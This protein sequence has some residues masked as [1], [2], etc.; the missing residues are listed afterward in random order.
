MAVVT[1]VIKFNRT[2]VL[3]VPKRIIPEHERSDVLEVEICRIGSDGAPEG[4]S[5][6]LYCLHNPESRRAFLSLFQLRPK[7]GEPFAIL[8]VR[9]YGLE[10]FANDYNKVRP[11]SLHNT[12]LLLVDARLVMRVGDAE[13]TIPHELK[14]NRGHVLLLG[15]FGEHGRQFKITKCLAGFKVCL[16][17]RHSPVASMKDESGGIVIR[18][19]DR[20]IPEDGHRTVIEIEGAKPLMDSKHPISS[21]SLMDGMRIVSK[22]MTFEGVYTLRSSQRLERFVRNKLSSARG[23]AQ[24]SHQRG[25]IAEGIINSVLARIGCHEVVDHPHGSGWGGQISEKK[26]PDSLRFTIVNHA[27]A[28]FEFKWWSNALLAVSD[29]RIQVRAYRCRFP[30]Y[31]ETLVGAAY[32]AV[33]DWE[34]GKLNARLIIKRA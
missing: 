28:Y 20:R 6:L 11:M 1:R 22:P 31:G 23:F 3:Y 34:T 15:R 10:E 5:H 2:S 8:G 16:M 13:V 4:R 26:G 7:P 27:L 29:S 14:S 24:Y 12:R 32:A 21:P 18:Y 19:R 33:L 17:P 25:T 30:S 9:R